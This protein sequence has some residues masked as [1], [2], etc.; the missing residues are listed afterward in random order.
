MKVVTVYLR[1]YAACAV[2]A[3]RAIA[4]SPWT[5]TLPILALGAYMVVASLAM[6]LGPAAGIALSFAQAAL[7]SAYFYFVREGVAGAKVG[8][9]EV[10]KSLG[11]YLW[12]FV[13]GNAFTRVELTIDRP[14]VPAR[15]PALASDDPR[16][17]GVRLLGVYFE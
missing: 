9:G 5:V 6:R 1:L 8:L 16:E 11:A 2:G 14:F 17:L 12:A 15:I 10:G 4:Q 7:L 3:F 13:G